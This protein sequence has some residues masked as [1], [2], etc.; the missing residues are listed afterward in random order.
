LIDRV[1]RRALAETG[2]ARPLD[3]DDAD[4]VLV[5]SCGAAIPG[6]E[7]RVVDETGRELPD[8]REGRI[9]FRGP[10]ATSGYFRNPEKTAALFVGEWLDADDAGYTVDGEIFVTARTKDMIIRA[11]RNIFPAEFET[12]IGEIDGIQ[13]G[14]VAVFGVADETTGTEKVVVMAESRRRGEDAVKAQRVAINELAWELIDGPPDDVRLVP[15]RT[16]PKTS[17]G[18][19]RRQAAK[20][21]YLSGET[22]RRPDPVWRQIAHVALASIRPAARRAIRAVAAQAFA[23]Y[24]YVVL[25]LVGLIGWPITVI[26]PTLRLRWAIMRGAARIM[27]LLTATPVRV[28]GRR[29]LPPDGAPYIVVTNH[30]SYLDGLAVAMAIPRPIRFVAK[31]ELLGSFVARVFLRRLGTHFVE[32][33]ELRKSLADA[34][35]AATEV[36]SGGAHVYFPEATFSRMPGLLPFQMGAFAAAADAGVP[37]VPLAIRGTRAMLRGDSGFLRPGRIEVT[38]GAPIAPPPPQDMDANARWREAVRLRDLARAE[39]LALCGEPDLRHERAPL[40][41]QAAK[42]PPS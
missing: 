19:I 33:F 10:S 32:R 21:I 18:K 26:A 38:I 25:A 16:V 1:S 11:G 2:I 14:N 15:P 13:R 23:G 8:R 29:N 30:C 3:V 22:G 36:R 12:A 5:P 34:E 6:H 28:E 24:G 37:V 39:I 20:Q 4:A 42:A 7:I 35:R 31:A 27:A 41:K 9:Q 17:S 40:E